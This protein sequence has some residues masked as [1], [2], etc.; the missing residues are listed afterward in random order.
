MESMVTGKCT[1]QLLHRNSLTTLI[2][3][4]ISEISV[5]CCNMVDH[6]R[7]GMLR[8]LIKAFR[9]IKQLL[10]IV[11]AIKFYEPYNV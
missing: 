4:N 9:T 11:T 3:M 10:E 2:S 6:I 1:Y 8:E 5:H 7:L